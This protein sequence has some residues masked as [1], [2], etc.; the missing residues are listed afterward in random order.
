M[1]R[2]T[3]LVVL[4]IAAVPLAANA[5]GRREPIWN[6]AGSESA[7][8]NRNLRGPPVAYAQMAPGSSPGVLRQGLERGGQAVPGNTDVSD[9]VFRFAIPVVNLPGRGFDLN[10]ALRYS[11]RI[12]ARVGN[13]F[14]F[15]PDADWPAPGWS[16]GFGMM[17]RNVLIDAN[18]TRHPFS[19]IDPL[20]AR[21]TDGSRIDITWPGTT[22][23][24]RQVVAAYPDG[25][26][27]EFTEY[28]VGSAYPVRI[29]DRNGN[30]ITLTYRK[31][32]SPELAT[33]VDT[34]GRTVA[35]QYD[36]DDR[37]VGVRGPGLNGAL[38]T[39]LVLHYK[40][41]TSSFQLPNGRQDRFDDYF[42]DA[43][44]LPAA[45]GYNG[46]WFGDADSY[47]SL[48]MIR[49]LIWQTDMRVTGA[50]AVLQGTPA[51]TRT[52]GFAVSVPA[53]DIPRRSSVTETWL[54][55]NAT[56]VTR[57]N[58]VLN[59]F[60]RE[61]ETIYPGGT[62]LLQASN[63]TPGMVGSGL[64]YATS[65]LDSAGVV[66]ANQITE[67]E[68]GT[69]GATR[70]R[71]IERSVAN[72]GAIARTEYSY[73]PGNEVTEV[74]ELDY[75][76]AIA[77]RT[78]TEYVTDPGYAA[79]HIFSLP[80]VVRVFAGQGGLA[81]SRMDF[82]YDDTSMIPLPAVVQHS[83]EFNP[84]L[85]PTGYAH[86]NRG[87]LT[88]V[89]RYRE[90]GSGTIG[91]E[92][93]RTYDVTGNV[94]EVFSGNTRT[95]FTRTVGTQ[96]S[97]TEA[98]GIGSS[99]QNAPPLL[100]TRFEYDVPTGKLRAQKDPNGVRTEF[101]YAPSGLELD[102]V[103]T[104]G[105]NT[106]Y[107]RQDAG[108]TQI[109][110]V[111]D[112]AGSLIDRTTIQL[113][114][115]GRVVRT[116]R[117]ADGGAIDIRESRFDE[118]GRLA[119][120]S[121]PYRSGTNDIH[122]LSYEYDVL[123]RTILLASEDQSESRLYYDELQRPATA[124]TLQGSTIRSVDRWG[125]ER[126]YRNDVLGRLVEVVEPNAE[127]AGKVME[128]GA[129]LTTYS[130]DVLGN[131][132]RISQGPQTREFVYDSMGLLLRQRLPE[133]AATLNAV[134]RYVGSGLWS[135]VFT[136]NA[137]GRLISATDARG[138]RTV[139]D[140]GNDPLDR[141]R[142]ISYDTSSFG[143]K[144]H[145]ISPLRP[146]TFSYV[147]SGDVRRID[148]F[149]IKLQVTESYK[150]DG[151]GRLASA[152]TALSPFR[153]TPLVFDYDYDAAGRL[154]HVR[155]PAQW[156]APAA[157]RRE[158]VNS[159]GA[160]GH[161]RTKDAGSNWKLTI[162]DYEPG[163]IPKSWQW[164]T[165]TTA[166]IPNVVDAAGNVVM[167]GGI[168]PAN[169]GVRESRG[170]DPRNQREIARTGVPINTVGAAPQ[171][172]LDLTKG[173][174][175]STFQLATAGP[176]LIAA[177]GPAPEIGEQLTSESD[178]SQNGERREYEYDALGRLVRATEGVT[179]RPAFTGGTV[180]TYR[181]GQDYRYD[182]FGNRI[183]VRAFGPPLP[184][185]CTT[186]PCGPP[187]TPELPDSER[188]GWR[189]FMVDPATN[190]IVGPGVDY[191]AA[192]NLVSAPQLGG[193]THTYKYD[194]AGRLTE[195]RSNG[196][197]VERYTYSFG[198]RRIGSFDSKNSGIVYAW[199]GD[200][201]AAEFDAKSGG[202]LSWRRTFIRS[203]PEVLASF[204]LE[205]GGEVFDVVSNDGVGARLLTRVQPAA[206]AITPARTDTLPF[207]RQ[208]AGRSVG[209]SFVNFMRSNLTGL[210]YAT[211][212]FYAPELGRFLQ[213]DPLA[214]GAADLSRPQTLNPYSYAA[215]DPVN[216]S[217]PMGLRM[218]QILAWDSQCLANNSEEYGIA[219]CSYTTWVYEPDMSS[220]WNP[221]APTRDPFIA[222]GH[223]LGDG[224][225]RGRKPVARSEP[226]NFAKVKACRNAAWDQAGLLGTSVKFGSL[227]SLIAEPEEFIEEFLGSVVMK[228][229]G[230]F[231][232]KHGLQFQ[233]ADLMVKAMGPIDPGYGA[234]DASVLSLR[235]GYLQEARETAALS[236]SVSAFGR[237]AGR[238]GLYGIAAAT[239]LDGLQYLT[240][241]DP[242]GMGAALVDMPPM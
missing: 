54:R 198:N 204:S 154:E 60:I 74:R 103:V 201:V 15:D 37:L 238:A 24:P 128:A 126:W 231:V 213:T 242:E 173:Y 218:R 161:L 194:A 188:D 26:V 228:G 40:N 225:E 165:E 109:R 70:V 18:G 112:S 113:D 68:A 164:T 193:G 208:R 3:T 215:N 121:L 192:G 34:V 143:D 71:A 227:G 102:L 63:D 229:G 119:Q 28:A 214:L 39:Y 89:I 96:Y 4:L 135:D 212:R 150:Y 209:A 75:N 88:R 187:A 134:G 141:L 133:R 140:Y 138:V 190:H 82:H 217:D 101:T 57:Y 43:V 210:D 195:I 80:S 59:G 174:E 2:K 114:G 200:F 66:K 90:A 14:A 197:L 185:Q 157:S 64:I 189:T 94:V 224:I 49:K 124:S 178:A 20:H 91:I 129:L 237:A 86:A 105:L 23:L 236:D 77:R 30:L 42:I 222:P 97:L 25:H 117:L 110:E 241:I 130:Y 83:P 191:D 62:R 226:S 186:V 176:Q 100:T 55:G 45:G 46:Y 202:N 183:S 144:S 184:T 220:E 171:P 67:W 51:F 223:F 149:T 31:A 219:T 162:S 99:A 65:I 13:D 79:A 207:G 50:G 240:C 22:A 169:V 137:F 172:I 27:V 115:R 41:V 146:V 196:T 131:L 216:R 52:Y 6:D 163:G 230:L 61:R 8:E 48:G 239:I 132:L 33:I 234:T 95:S 136:Y 182:R 36:A 159:Y 21:T 5:L 19:M 147:T 92:E 122:W 221:D 32:K 78:T 235:E 203:G 12:W 85:T 211:H 29:V 35:F 180:K 181:S 72:S 10:I 17:A 156:N 1:M 167:V 120:Q 87:N 145:P 106:R 93:R 148:H 98:V 81:A 168:I 160:A 76:G 107:T 206:L 155:Y 53:G 139:F 56:S 142:S 179:T 73:G 123:G 108:L 16:I 175:G 116:E 177:A 158:V 199:N 166:A 58:L 151:A 153:S 44:L 152:S 233:S 38:R 104:G 111:Q 205:N 9:G 69:F 7:T 170:L 47:Q 84:W 127:G 125:R 11:S 118:L 232:I